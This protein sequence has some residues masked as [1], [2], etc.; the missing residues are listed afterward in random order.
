MYV[1][2]YHNTIGN[3]IENSGFNTPPD[4]NLCNIKNNPQIISVEAIDRDVNLPILK[5]LLLNEVYEKI[6]MINGI[7]Y[8]G[9][10]IS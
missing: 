8:K 9:A 3:N 2:I 7:K 10:T 1:I 4:E 6:K 5:N